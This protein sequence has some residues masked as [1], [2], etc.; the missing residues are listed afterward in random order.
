MKYPISEEQARAVFRAANGEEP[1][2]ELMQRA[3]AWIAVANDAYEDGRRDAL[4]ELAADHE[5]FTDQVKDEAV[6]A[7]IPKV[8]SI[9]TNVSYKDAVKAA[10]GVALDDASGAYNFYKAHREAYPEWGSVGALGVVFA[11]GRV[12]GVRRERARRRRKEGATV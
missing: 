8:G 2:E 4:A 10:N 9:G 1:S 12:D 6:D 11:A 5:I 3:L 7:A